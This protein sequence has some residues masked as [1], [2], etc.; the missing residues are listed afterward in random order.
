MGQLNYRDGRRFFDT[1]M[2]FPSRSVRNGATKLPENTVAFRNV[3]IDATLTPDLN[4]KARTTID[5]Y[6]NART[7]RVIALELSRK[8]Q[9]TDVRLNREPVEFFVRES[10]RSNLLRGPE[11]YTFLI[12]LPKPLEAGESRTIE[13]A[14]EGAVINSAGHGVYY[15]GARNNWYPS[16]DGVFSTYDLKFRYPNNLQMVSTGDV[17][18]DRVEGEWRL[19]QRRVSVPIRFAGFNLG[20][21]YEKASVTRAGFTIDVYANRAVE[22]ALQS[23]PKDYLPQ[24]PAGQPRPSRRLQPETLATPVLTL[25]PDPKA[26]LRALA[27]EVG[28]AMEFM[29]ANFG[30]PPLKTLTVSP[31]PGL[32]DRAFRGCCIC[33]LSPISSPRICPWRC[34]PTRSAVSFLNCSTPTR[35]RINGGETLSRQAHIRTI[36]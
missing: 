32:S 1:W 27:D 30:P 21:D 16:R 19:T 6:A 24:A 7:D 26:R 12:V 15:V 36:G 33:L 25:P 11:N 3:A 17:V 22:S 28:A 8:M 5:L 4:M 9:L 29:S 35:Q 14:H 18:E 31:I 20:G 13:V 10:M 34:E 23:P 2:S